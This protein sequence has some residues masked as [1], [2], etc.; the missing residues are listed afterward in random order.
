MN[1]RLIAISGPLEGATF[2]I[3][4]ELSI[5]RDRQNT[6]A[7]EDRVLSRRHC[8]IQEGDGKCSLRDLGSSNGTYVNGLPVTMRMLDDGDQITAGQNLFLFAC[9]AAAHARTGEVEMDHGGI[10]PLSTVMLKPEDAIYL[11]PEE[12]PEI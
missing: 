5:G 9:G 2:P 7:I 12:L 10:N 1:A 8:A 11:R 3:D 4:G 6:L